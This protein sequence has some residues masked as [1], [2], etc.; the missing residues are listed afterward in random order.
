LWYRSDAFEFRRL[1]GVDHAV[2]S[3]RRA[4][5]DGAVTAITLLRRIGGRDFS[6]REGELLHFLHAELGRLVRRSLVSALEP[7]P[8]NLPPRLRQ[9]LACLLEGDSEK[10]VAARL[11][12]SPT[13]VHEYVGELYRRFGVR[14]RA[15]LLAHA[16][17]R[18]ADSRWR[19]VAPGGAEH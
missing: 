17:K 9:T 11:A 15:Q 16:L 8:E 6:P 10:Q 19:N 3:V 1:A 2:V 14:S 7:S 4:S 18:A 5:A 12:L 13:T